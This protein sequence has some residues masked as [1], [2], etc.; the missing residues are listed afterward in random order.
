[1]LHDSLKEEALLTR[2]YRAFELL[3]ARVTGIRYLLEGRLA[4][5]E[6]LPWVPTQTSPHAFR[7]QT[8]DENQQGQQ[9]AS[10]PLDDP[11]RG[12]FKANAIAPLGIVERS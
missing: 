5:A 8:L 2:S 7:Q 4:A 10:V 11:S 1:M 9:E 6:R 3:R 12:T